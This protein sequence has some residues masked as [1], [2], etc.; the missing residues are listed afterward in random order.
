MYRVGM[1]GYQKELR[2]LHEALRA[3]R[4][5]EGRPQAQTLKLL[6][7]ARLSLEVY[8]RAMAG[9]INTR[10]LVGSAF[11]YIMLTE[12]ALRLGGVTTLTLD[13]ARQLVEAQIKFHSQGGRDETGRLVPLDVQTIR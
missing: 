5:A 3:L 7:H 9:V 12:Q 4:V 8:T 1:A 13:A 6:R 2:L 10:D 11:K